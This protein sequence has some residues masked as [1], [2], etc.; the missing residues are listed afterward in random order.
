MLYV[1]RSAQHLS[2]VGTRTELM[3]LLREA[4]DDVRYQS[5]T[6]TASSTA[7]PLRAPRVSSASTRRTVMGVGGG[8]GAMGGGAGE[9]R[10]GAFGLSMEQREQVLAA[11]LSKEKVSCG[12]SEEATCDVC[13]MREKRD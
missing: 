2:E 8:G 12:V 4:V 13:C 3:Q 5:G 9:E 7:T 1:E 6:L 11:L 10:R